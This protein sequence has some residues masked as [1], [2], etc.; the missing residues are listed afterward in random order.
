[1]V[2]AHTAVPDNAGYMEI[3]LQFYEVEHVKVET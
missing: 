3:E 1:M 2:K